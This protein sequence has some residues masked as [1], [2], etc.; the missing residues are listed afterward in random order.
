MPVLPFF[1]I[2]SLSVGGT[3]S[4]QITLC[5]CWKSWRYRFTAIF[6]GGASPPFSA[7]T[8][9]LHQSTF[10]G[11]VAGFCSDGNLQSDL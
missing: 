9:R 1:P 7:G 10:L 5:F 8:G 11:L 3:V 4:G 2:I 6:W